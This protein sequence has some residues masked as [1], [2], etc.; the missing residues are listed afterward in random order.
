LNG[1]KFIR[2]IRF[3]FSATAITWFLYFCLSP[4]LILIFESYSS[5]LL[6]VEYILIAEYV[7]IAGILLYVLWDLIRTYRA[8][9]STTRQRQQKPESSL[10]RDVTTESKELNHPKAV[11]YRNQVEAL[12]FRRLGEAENDYSISYVFTNEDNST[13]AVVSLHNKD[14]VEVFFETVFKDKFFLITGYNSGMNIDV[15]RM[16]QRMFYTSIDKAHTYHLQQQEKQRLQRGEPVQINTIAQMI[17]YWHTDTNRLLDLYLK[18]LKRAY[19]MTAFFIILVLATM[20]FGICG[21]LIHNSLLASLPVWTFILLAYLELKLNPEL[22]P[23]DFD[24]HK[25][26]VKFP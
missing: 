14:R 16:Q 19:F 24:K 21:L 1:E 2:F 12:D 7:S 10:L 11:D 3:I 18:I 25:R 20:P 5:H 15:D 13:I 26:K 17:D 4:F 23:V 9:M 8:G 22:I 6:V